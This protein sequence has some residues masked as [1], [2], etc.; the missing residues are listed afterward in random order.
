MLA[1]S[2]QTFVVL[3]CTRYEYDECVSIG[4]RG[5]VAV[6]QVGLTLATLLE[7]FGTAFLGTADLGQLLL[8]VLALLQTHAII[9]WIIVRNGLRGVR[10]R[11]A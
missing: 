11:A 7:E 4:R 10:V 2:G 1:T 6:T 9:N 8:A 3:V 5:L